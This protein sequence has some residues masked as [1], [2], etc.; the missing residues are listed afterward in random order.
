V[1]H[2]VVSPVKN[3]VFGWWTLCN[4]CVEDTGALQS[5]LINSA[6]SAHHT[7]LTVWYRMKIYLKLNIPYL[8]NI[9]PCW[10]VYRYHRFG[11]SNCVHLKGS[12]RRVAARVKLLGLVAL[13]SAQAVFVVHRGIWKEATVD[14][15][16]IPRGERV[17]EKSGANDLSPR[18]PKE[19][20]SGAIADLRNRSVRLTA[21]EPHFA[22]PDYTAVLTEGS[23]V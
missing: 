6:T 17:W 18:Y 13:F 4:W 10:L 15:Q 22:Y 9:T 20:L 16:G 1:C 2:G 11:G 14:F 12:R 21:V 23:C 3:S 5:L 8:L 7:T 19:T